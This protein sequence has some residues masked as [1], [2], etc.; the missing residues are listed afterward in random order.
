VEDDGSDD[1]MYVILEG[2]VGI[3]QRQKLNVFKDDYE[4]FMSGCREGVKGLVFGGGGRRW[5]GGEVGGGGLVRS[6]SRVGGEGRV[7]SPV[8]KAGGR[9][10]GGAGGFM[11]GGIKPIAVEKEPWD[12]A[13]NIT[14]SPTKKPRG[15]HKAVTMIRQKAVPGLVNA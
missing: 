11:T 12:N 3:Y 6:G 10:V 5:E 1:R 9:E 4:A 2:S 13:L 7:G 14:I 15:V 8:G